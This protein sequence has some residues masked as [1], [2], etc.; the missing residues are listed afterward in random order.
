MTRQGAFR[1][2]AA[3]TLRAATTPEAELVALDALAFTAGELQLPDSDGELIGKLADQLRASDSL[4]STL[5][6]L[7]DGQMKLNLDGRDGAQ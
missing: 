5:R 7:F 2:I 4:R 3:H 1:I 6:D